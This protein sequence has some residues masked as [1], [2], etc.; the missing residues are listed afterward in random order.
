MRHERN[1]KTRCRCF[2]CGDEIK[3]EWVTVTSCV[4]DGV[5]KAVFICDRCADEQ[6]DDRDCDYEVE[7]E[8]NEDEGE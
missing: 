4:D 3:K 7:R 2:F 8:E 5:T 1:G 6:R